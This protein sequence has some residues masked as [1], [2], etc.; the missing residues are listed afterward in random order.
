MYFHI[1]H[2]GLCMADTLYGG[3]FPGN[4]TAPVPTTIVS[5]ILLLFFWIG[6]ELLYGRKKRA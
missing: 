1:Q 4:F 3:R 2:P 6:G 5:V